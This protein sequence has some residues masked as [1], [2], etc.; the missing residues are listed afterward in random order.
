LEPAGFNVKRSNFNRKIIEL[1]YNTEEAIEFFFK[2]LNPRLPRNCVLCVVPS[3]RKG[4]PRSGV[5]RLAK[6][7]S[8]FHHR[9]D[10]TDL[11]VRTA[12]ISKLAYGVRRD[13]SIHLESIEVRD[14]S[15]VRTAGSFSCTT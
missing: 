6:R 2:Q 12:T 14:H 10:G 11:L 5:Q 8:L 1:K 9:I 15:I 3:H 4:A 13:T 7:L